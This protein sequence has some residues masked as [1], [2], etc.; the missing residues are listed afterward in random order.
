MRMRAA[1]DAALVVR[2][3]LVEQHHGAALRQQ[4]ADGMRGRVHERET[5]TVLSPAYGSQT[6]PGR[7]LAIRPRSGNDAEAGLTR[8]S[9]G[10]PCGQLDLMSPGAMSTEIVCAGDAAGATMRATQNGSGTFHRLDSS[11]G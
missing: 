7:P 9:D 5:T 2:H 11:A 4:V 10:T 6:R 3:D 1:D 8:S